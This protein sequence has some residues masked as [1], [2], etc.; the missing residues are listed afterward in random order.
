[1]TWVSGGSHAGHPNDDYA[2]RMVQGD[3]PRWTQGH[4][5]TLVP[6]EPISA[7]EDE[8]ADATFAIVAPWLKE[9]WDDP[10]LDTG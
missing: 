5:L 1:M 8:G 9:V 3:Y 4:E 2:A 7:G 6:L 10:E